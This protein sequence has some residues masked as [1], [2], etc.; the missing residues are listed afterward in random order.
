MVQVAASSL[1]APTPYPPI[2]PTYYNSNILRS[3]TTLTPSSFNGC[4]ED[5]RYDRLVPSYR[6]STRDGDHSYDFEY[7]ERPPSHR[8]SFIRSYS[9]DTSSSSSTEDKARGGDS[10]HNIPTTWRGGEA[11]GHHPPAP[12][13]TLSSNRLQSRGGGE[14]ADDEGLSHL[15]I[16]TSRTAT[17]EE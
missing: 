10:S 14:E 8:Q 5:E 16:K 3:A 11:A 6:S 2:S 7:P 9:E 4:K 13:P 17:R 15:G 1:N 12:S